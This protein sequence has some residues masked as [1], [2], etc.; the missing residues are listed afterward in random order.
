M[1]VPPLVAS[2]GVEAQTCVLLQGGV[3]RA[4]ASYWNAA[5]LRAGH[6]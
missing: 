2:E 3:V 6:G 4:R 5:A 1:I